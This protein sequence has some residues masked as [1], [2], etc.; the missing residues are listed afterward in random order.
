MMYQRTEEER[1][2][3]KIMVKDAYQK[4]F[5]HKHAK[6]IINGKSYP[7]GVWTSYV[8]KSWDAY[9]LDTFQ[10]YIPVIAKKLNISADDYGRFEQVSYDIYA[11]ED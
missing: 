4:N 2:S 10:S 5:N 7:F 11:E 1:A 3:D 6:I 9:G 8:R